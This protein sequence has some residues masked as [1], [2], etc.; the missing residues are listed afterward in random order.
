MRTLGALRGWV[1]P[2]I[3]IVSRSESPLQR[4]SIGARASISGLFRF[5]LVIKYAKPP[6]LDG[7]YAMMK[8]EQKMGSRVKSADQLS[9]KGR[10]RPVPQSEDQQLSPLV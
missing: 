5:D 6:V 10:G 2:L 8:E 7:G 4:L 9:R 3:S 1:P